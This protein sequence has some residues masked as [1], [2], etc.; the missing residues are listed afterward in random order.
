MA[1]HAGHE[2]VVNIN[3]SAAQPSKFKADSKSVLLK[4]LTDSQKE[5]VQSAARRVL[6]IAGAGSGKTEVMARRVAWWVAVNGVARDSIVA[7]TFTERAAEEMKFRIRRYV[8]M[9]TA[10][11]QDATLGGMYI[12]TIHGFCVNL[13]RQLAP[14][15]Y[16]NYDVLDESGRLALVQRGYHGTLGLKHLETALGSG[17]YATMGQF[18]YGYDLL[19]E[20][21][22]LDVNLCS[23]PLPND[24]AKEA[25]WCKTSSINTDIGRSE[26][27]KAFGNSAA[28]Y[29]SY[30]RSRR[31][32]DFSTSQTEI[33]RLLRSKKKALQTVRQTLTHLVVDEVQDINTVQDR[34]IRLIIGDSGRLTAVGDHR[35]AI[36][37]WRGGRVELM[38]K[39]YKEF[40]GDKDAKLVELA[41]NYRSTPRIIAIAN[42][43]AKTIGTPRP[44]TSPDMLHG[45]LPRKDADPTHVAALDFDDRD[46]EAKWIGTTIQELVS[47]EGS[48]ARHDTPNGDRGL[49]YADVAVLLRSST[50]AR[51][52]ME[53]LE[54]QDVPAVFRAGPDLF[55]QPEVLLFLGALARMAGLDQFL[56]A[57]WNPKSLP[58][59]IDDVLGCDPN[60]EAVIVAACE[61]LRKAGLP[62]SKSAEKRLLLATDLIHKRI[63]G[64]PP[65][66]RQ[67]L[68]SLRTPQLVKW[69][70][71]GKPPRRVFPQTLFQFTVA[72][73]E[74]GE[75]EAVVRRGGTAMFH[76]GALSALV[77]GMETPGWTSAGDFRFQVIALCLWGAENARTDEAPLLVQP[78]AVTI[79]TIHAAKGLEFGA[80]FLADVASRRFPSQNARK[81]S[82][83]PFD[84]PVASKIDPASLADNDNYD[85]ERR[86]M[87]VALTRAER[88]LFVTTCYK[89]PFFKTVAEIVSAQGG[90]AQPASNFALSGIALVKSEFRR[91]FRLATSFSDLRYYLEC[92]H[93]FYLRKVLG[94]APAID[95]AFGYG[96]G[97]HNL[98]RAIHSDPKTWAKLARDPDAL[99]ARLDELVHRGLFYLRYTTAQPMENMRGR[100][101]QIVSDYVQTYAAELEKLTFEPEKPFETLIEEEQLLVSGAIDVVRLDDP[102]RVSL[103]DFKSGEQGS[104]NALKLS[105]E[106]MRL[107]VSLYGLAAKH[108]LE[109]EPDRGMVRYLGEPD[110]SKRELL[111][112]LNDAA[113]G[114]ARKTVA[115]AA[116]EIRKRNFHRGPIA[117]PRDSRFDI[118]CGE[119]DFVGF[120]GQQEA[121]EFRKSPSWGK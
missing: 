88:Y 53:A 32:L 111:I 109:Y 71:S 41:A 10:E 33:L 59:R 90:T 35:Q 8:Q 16:H 94:F 39:L 37:G 116:A 63:S 47:A 73:A 18:L 102:P 50:S 6:L 91:D 78:D 104:D 19:N 100:A 92:P 72:E 79:T 65:A 29:Y 76:L 20:Y 110:S 51:A 14:D 7:F 3:E 118:R 25:D 80:V 97:V 75:W 93:D 15:D 26:Q 98:M 86:L 113:L 54:K 44:M 96:R 28:R 64:E 83:L 120:C 87:Y 27:S 46:E 49:C 84:G 66:P 1:C 5:A 56:G 89:S 114:E 31:F 99:K 57:A 17:Y 62:I 67:V 82:S 12:G 69:L 30:L 36:F 77:K 112:D 70:S 95:Q 9:V 58:K 40:K 43:W 22:E 13:L 108:E 119:C 38:A 107:Q 48:G 103:I 24:V 2:G 85:Q 106:E 4:D 55:S 45:K 21:D 60:P 34:L 61:K 121:K 11:G 115:E 68:A 101:V 74:V 42:D 105:E 117:K 23:E 52:Y 81:V